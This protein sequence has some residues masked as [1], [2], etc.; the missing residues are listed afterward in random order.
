M[1]KVFKASKLKRNGQPL[2]CHL[3]ML[4]DTFA[5]EKLEA[6]ATIEEVSKLLGHYDIRTTQ[7]HYL[8]WDRRTQ[9]R[10]K[11]AAMVDWDQNTNSEAFAIEKKSPK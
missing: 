5:I 11:K 3:H 4:R 6:G 2:R 7:K 9:E 10:L 1:G 8:P